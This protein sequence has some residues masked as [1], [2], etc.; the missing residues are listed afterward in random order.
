MQEHTPEFTYHDRVIQLIESTYTDGV[1][2]S[3]A[4]ASAFA[5][6][7]RTMEQPVILSANSCVGR[8]LPIAH[9]TGR[10]ENVGRDCVTLCVNDLVCSGARPLFFISYAAAHKHDDERGEQIVF[11]IAAAC[12]EAG[13]AFL[14]GSRMEKANVYADGRYDLA[15]FAV[16]VCDRKDLIDGHEIAPGDIL[17]GLASSG[18]HNDGIGLLR[19]TY[20][21]NT[22]TLSRVIPE[23]SC[24]LGEELLK[25]FAMYVNPILYLTRTLHMK[26]KGMAH[27][28]D[29][30]FFRNVPRMLPDGVRAY[31]TPNTFPIPTIYDLIAQKGKISMDEMFRNFNMGTGLIMAVSKDDVGAVYNALIQTGERPYMA[32]YCADGEKG[33][34]L[35][36]RGS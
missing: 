36:W 28:S 30:G 32:G 23:L 35:N 3:D 1:I 19:S 6:D 4:A 34:E 12:R 2:R 26:I 14:G 9:L 24:T 29:G 10:H 7:L 18:I 22:R 27:I 20:E 16:G 25:P 21:L 33:V 13:C 15:G 31:I 11:G 17:L 8:K 5:P